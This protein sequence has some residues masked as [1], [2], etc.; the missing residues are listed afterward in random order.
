MHSLPILKSWQAIQSV[1]EC[2]AGPANET[3]WE[4]G[5]PPSVAIDTSPLQVGTESGNI[6]GLD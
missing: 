1:R 4:Q 3:G 6:T 2:C 5:E